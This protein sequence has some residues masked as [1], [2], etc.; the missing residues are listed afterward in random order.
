[1]A[2]EQSATTE[3]VSESAEAMSAQVEH[4]SDQA[5]QLSA[6]AEQL[7]RLVARFSLEQAGARRGACQGSA[8]PPRRVAAHTPFRIVS[9]SA[10][11]QMDLE[12]MVL[13]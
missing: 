13:T 12:E 11:S 4:M 5:R 10:T 2:H 1:M 7:K 8:A 6:T 9:R 3:E